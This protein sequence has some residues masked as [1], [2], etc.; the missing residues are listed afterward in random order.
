MPGQLKRS[1]RCPLCGDGLAALVDE[2]STGGVRREYYHERGSPKARRRRCV[3]W[4]SDREDAAAERRGLE[5]R[6]RR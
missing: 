1:A 6:Q 4:F 2:S 3:K 5:V